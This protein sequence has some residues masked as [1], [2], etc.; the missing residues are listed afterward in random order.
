VLDGAKAAGAQTLGM[1]TELP[2]A[3]PP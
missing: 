2:E 3:P 1:M